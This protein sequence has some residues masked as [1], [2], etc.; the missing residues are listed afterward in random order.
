MRYISIALRIITIVSFSILIVYSYKLADQS[1]KIYDKYSHTY[2]LLAEKECYETI[3]NDLQIEMMTLN[4]DI[5]Y[6]SIDTYNG[7]NIA[8]LIGGLISITTIVVSFF[9]IM[10]SKN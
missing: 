3:D 1:E 10:K 4:D 7:W 2:N 9:E 6:H 5:I 8:L